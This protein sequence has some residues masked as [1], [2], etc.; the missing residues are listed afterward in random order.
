MLSFSLCPHHTR[1][2]P[3]SPSTEAAAFFSDKAATATAGFVLAGC[4]MYS[5]QT[6][7]SGQIASYERTNDNLAQATLETDDLMKQT[8]KASRLARFD[9]Q[10]SDTRK[11]RKSRKKSRMLL[12]PRASNQPRKVLAKLIDT[13]SLSQSFLQRAEAVIIR[14]R[15]YNLF[16]NLLWQAKALAIM[17]VG[18]G[19]KLA[20]YKP[21][22]SATAHYAFQQRLLLS[23]SAT[24]VFFIQLF[25]ALFIKTRHH[26]SW[27]TLCNQPLHTAL[28]AVRIILLAASGSLCTAQLP[29]M[30]FL[31]VQTGTALLQCAL[32]HLLDFKFAVTSGNQHPMRMMPQALHALH[33]NRIKVRD[34][35]GAQ[36]PGSR[37]SPDALSA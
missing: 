3:Q 22:A 13:T 23:L 28:V 35:A 20:I 27:A 10:D 21:N 34:E 7:V 18:V 32:S 11:S 8:Q 33:Q 6:M 36:S 25:H 16:N 37:I 26:Y 15:L 19:V 14:M 12:A 17:L 4:M 24:G 2:L 29:P 31:W 9:A 1:V 30:I 5:F